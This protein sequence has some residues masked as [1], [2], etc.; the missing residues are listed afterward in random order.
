MVSG[1]SILWSPSVAS[2]G[3][4]G[5]K[6]STL[7]K[8][9][10][11]GGFPGIQTSEFLWNSL[12]FGLLAILYGLLYTR[13]H[14]PSY[15]GKVKGITGR[16]PDAGVSHHRRICQASQCQS[17]VAAVLRAD[18]GADA[19]PDRSVHRVPVLCAGTVDRDGYDPDVSGTGHPAERGTAVPECRSNTGYPALAAGRAAKGAGK[20]ASVAG[21][22]GPDGG[23]PS[24]GGR[25]GKKPGTGWHLS[26]AAGPAPDPAGAL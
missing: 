2:D 6:K 15:Y 26:T 19:G 14:T 18:R 1:N 13:D 16:N 22:P 8:N 23:C 4:S 9:A 17:E 25:G 10:S 5:A 12:C 24:P 7:C 20:D 3:L 11:T 21:Y